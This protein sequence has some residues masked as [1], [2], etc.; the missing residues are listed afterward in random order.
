MEQTKMNPFILNG[1]YIRSINFHNTPYFR[2]EE[3]ES[4]F[5]FYRD[6]FEPVSEEDLDEFFETKRWNK[7]KP[8]LI[9]NFYNGY[10]NNFDTMYPILEKYDFI[11]WFFLATEFLSIPANQQKKYASDHTLLL[12]TNEYEDARFALSWDEVRELSKRHVIASHTKTHSE[13]IESSTDEDMVREIIGSKFEIEEQIQSEISAFVW[14][15]GK[16]FAGN[17]YAA[18]YLHQAGYR[19]LFSNLK[20]EKINK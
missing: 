17:P 13:L 12:G 3:Y 2:V 16:E 14:L 18:S 7:K 15:G 4:Q 11:G 8:G 6:H 10:R 19:Y 9:I 20:I 1:S 5:A